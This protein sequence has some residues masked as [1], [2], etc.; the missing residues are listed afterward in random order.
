[1]RTA[2]AGRRTAFVA[3]PARTAWRG[4][5]RRIAAGPATPRT[6]RGSRARCA[7]RGRR[8]PGDAVPR[9]RSRRRPRPGVGPGAGRR[10]ARPGAPRRGRRPGGAR[11]GIRPSPRALGA[12]GAPDRAVR[13]RFGGARPRD[14]RAEDHRRGG[15]PDVPG[16][17]AC[18]RRGRARTAGLRLPPTPR[19]SRALPYHAFHPLGLER[20]RA[21]L[22]RS[23]PA[24][25]RGSS[26]SRSRRPRRAP[27]RGARPRSRAAYAALRRS[28]GS[29]RGP[30]PRS[31]SARSATPDAVSVGD[32]HIPNMVCWALAGEPRG[33]DERMLELLEP[34]PGPA[35]PR[36]ALLELAGIAAPRYGPRLASRRIRRSSPLAASPRASPTA[37]RTRSAGRGTARRR[38]PPARAPR[39]RS[40]PRARA[41]PARRPG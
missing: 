28:R 36:D 35:R 9:S 32:F 26:A 39:R 19:R 27:A 6:G 11:P 7:R 8:R 1:M 17:R 10:R 5:S 16:A 24:R 31:G 13:R 4:R 15:A 40:R 12:D 2:S 18:V 14:P 25:R 38:T 3:I 21:E 41:A 37:S 30:R 34:L 22:V 20:R 33:T 29:A 23:S